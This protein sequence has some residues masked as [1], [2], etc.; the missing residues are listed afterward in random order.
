M[1]ECEEER[2]RE[3]MGCYSVKIERLMESYEK[4]ARA[5]EVKEKYKKV[6]ELMETI[7]KKKADNAGKSKE[8]NELMRENG[9][10][11]AQLKKT[12]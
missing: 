2:E 6:S 9:H 4:K 8:W 12:Q 3:V 10:M 5:E 11:K 7:Q 1:G